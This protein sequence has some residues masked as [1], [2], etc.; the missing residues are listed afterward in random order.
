MLIGTLQLQF[1][2]R[3]HQ[4]TLYF[5]IYKENSNNETIMI[6]SFNWMFMILRFKLLFSLAPKNKN[7]LKIK[8]SISSSFLH[9]VT[10]HN[11][12]QSQQTRVL[13]GSLDILCWIKLSYYTLHT[14]RISW[15]SDS[16][17]KN[18]IQNKIIIG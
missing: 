16:S 2:N 17:I 8:H 15:W 6:R 10:Q 12:K 7:T 18:Y 14:C 4:W 5:I 9:S 3:S 13:H 1:P 11:F